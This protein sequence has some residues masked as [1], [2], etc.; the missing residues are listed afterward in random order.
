MLRASV[1]DLIRGVVRGNNLQQAI[2]LSVKQV[3]TGETPLENMIDWL[4]TVI[5]DDGEFSTVETA[6]RAQVAE[7]AEAQASATANDPFG[8]NGLSTS[9]LSDRIKVLGN[10]LWY[11]P[12]DNSGQIRDEFW[13][14]IWRLIRYHHYTDDM[15]L[16]LIRG[17]FPTGEGYDA[18][19]LGALVSLKF[20]P[21][22]RKAWRH[23]KR[24]LDRVS[25]K[26]WGVNRKTFAI[27]LAAAAALLLLAIFMSQL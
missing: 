12:E 4:R 10:K 27:A 6:V 11:D 3:M 20:D 9:D 13:E 25:G 7:G 5:E 19:G 1:W 16:R 15:L 14:V 18:T 24:Q 2:N 22:I 23:Q 26:L 21:L 17:H 8:L